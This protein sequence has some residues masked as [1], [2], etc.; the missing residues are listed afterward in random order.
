MWTGLWCEDYS[1]F[2][3]IEPQLGFLDAQSDRNGEAAIV[4]RV[5][6]VQELPNGKLEARFGYRN[7]NGV[8][9]TIPYGPRNL[10]V[11][12]RHGDRPTVFAPGDKAPRVQRA[13]RL[14]RS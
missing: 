8:S 1:I 14:D 5:E 11:I 7:D 6:C 3:R 4:P 13:V 9:V 10:F 2:T 12:D